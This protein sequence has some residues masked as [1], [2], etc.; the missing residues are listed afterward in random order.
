MRRLLRLFR[1]NNRYLRFFIIR[2]VR[3]DDF[4]VMFVRNTIKLG[5][6]RLGLSDLIAIRATVF[7]GKNLVLLVGN[8]LVNFKNNIA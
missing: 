1:R 3:I 5:R 7:R 6:V 2:T 8:N 4:I